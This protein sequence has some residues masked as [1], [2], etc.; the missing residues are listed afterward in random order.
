[1]YTLQHQ[2]PAVETVARILP[3]KDQ[4]VSCQK[5]TSRSWN[6]LVNNSLQLGELELGLVSPDNLSLS[7]AEIPELSS[8]LFPRQSTQSDCSHPK[9]SPL[10]QSNSLGVSSPFSAAVLFL[11][12]FLFARKFLK[13]IKLIRSLMMKHQYRQQR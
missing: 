6:S 1:M 7:S 13:R 12:I 8:E 9:Y 10:R 3:D 11:Q 5:L 4:S 2:S